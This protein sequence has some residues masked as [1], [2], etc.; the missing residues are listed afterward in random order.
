MRRPAAAKARGKAAARAPRVPAGRGRVRGG[1]RRP[2]AAPAVGVAAEENIV[3]KFEKGDE[4][5][6]EDLPTVAWKVGSLLAIDNGQYFGGPCQVAG[7]FREWSLVGDQVRVRLQVTGTS[8]EDLLKYVTGTTHRQV[9]VHLCS[10]G[11]T[12][13]PHDQ[14]L[15]H[16]RQGRLVPMVKE[17]DCTWET[18]LAA[19]EI[20][21]LARLRELQASLPPAG[22]PPAG[23]APKGEVKS[24]SSSG[25]AKKDKKK[26]KTRKKK[27]KD[28]KEAPG[29]KEGVEVKASSKRSYGGRTIGKKD[30][31]SLFAGTG[32]DPKPSIRR[33]VLQ[34]AKR[35]VNKKKDVTSSSSDDSSSTSG[36]VSSAEGAD[37]LM[38]GNKIKMMSRH[39]PGSLTMMGVVKMQEALTEQEGVWGLQ[40]S[41]KALPA[42]T[43]RYV[44]S[45]LGSRL[46][47][48]P[49]KEAITLASALDLLLQG[50]CAESA[51]MMVQRLKSMERVSQ[52]T[53]WSS[54]EK[55]ELAPALN[56]QMSS[57]SEMEAANKEARQDYKAKGGATT[58]FQTKSTFGKGKKGKSE[59]KG[60]GKGKRKNQDPPKT[61][62]TPSS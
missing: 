38:D 17:K 25:K 39:A 33:K 10:T 23:S 20:D 45:T 55:M 26:K 36:E 47:G 13:L 62:T 51:D 52:G 53:S 32:L 34:Y 48:G 22:V 56:P 18:N 28:K 8:H 12:A 35:K 44:R 40:E 4:V 59:E 21:E 42:V 19:E 37:V 24:S 60:P 57:R 27:K 58:T 15:L 9:E 54:A 7:R 1:L 46:N 3:A 43:L 61:S 6:L 30:L 5:V 29:E 2:A 49:L 31:S 50:R 11:C 14:G 16:A 41:S